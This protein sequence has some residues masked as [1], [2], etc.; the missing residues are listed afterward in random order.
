ME[1][2]ASVAGTVPS[3]S[4]LDFHIRTLLK[5]SFVPNYNILCSQLVNLSG[6]YNYDSTYAIRLPFDGIRRPFD[7]EL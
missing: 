2:V 3:S 1:N 7:V 4:S 6:G 5:L